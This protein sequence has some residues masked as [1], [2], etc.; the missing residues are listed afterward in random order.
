MP[1]AGISQAGSVIH[2]PKGADMTRSPLLS[3]AATIAV[4]LLVSLLAVSAY[5]QFQTGNIYGKVQAKDGTALPGV[6]VTL[7][8]VAAPQTFLTDSGGN[9]RFLNLSP[10]TYQVRAELSGFGTAVRKDIGVNVG[11]NAEIAITLNPSVEQSITVTAEA[12]LIDTRKTGTGAVVSRAELEQIPTGRDPWV[13]MGQAPGVQLDRVNVAGSE[14]GQQ[15]VVVAKGASDTQKTFNLDGV[16]ITDVGAIGSTPVYY[17]FDSFE[18]IQVTTGGSDPRIQTPGAQLNMVTKRGTNDFKGS[19]RYFLTKNSWQASAAAPSE[20]AAYL[21]QGNTINNVANWSGDVGGPIIKDKLWIWGSIARQDIK[22]FISQPVGADLTH[23]NT[24]LKDWNGKV[25]F[26]PLS[27]N[28]GTYLYTYGNKL[29]FGRYAATDHPQETTEDQ[30]GP[31]HMYKL[32]DTHIFNQNLYLTVLY[33]HVLSPFQFVPEGGNVQPYIDGDGIWHRSYFYYTTSRPQNSYRGDGSYFFKTAALDH[34]LKFGYGYR[35]APVTSLSTYPAT[36]VLGD[37]SQGF[38]G[39]APDNVNGIALLTRPGSNNFLIG[40]TDFYAGDTITTGNLTLQGGLRFDRQKGRNGANPITANPL[41]PDLLAAVT[42][43]A[44]TRELHWNSVSPRIGATYTVGTTH[45]T[46]LRASYN[47]YVDQLGGNVV[48]AGNPYNYAAGLYYYWTDLNHDKTVQRNE[49]GAYYGTYGNIDPDNPNA[50]PHLARLDYGMKPPKTDEFI[51]GAETQLLQDLSVGADYT[52]RKFT[53][54]WW[55]VHEKADGSFVGPNDYDCSSTITAA[56]PNGKS[57]TVPN[58]TLKSGVNIVDTV[59][60]NRPDYNQ[61]Y[62]GFDVFA[63]KRMTNNW[64]MR[65]SFSYNDRKQH[66]GA[67]GI[68]DPTPWLQPPSPITNNYFGCSSCDGAQVVDRSYG[69]HSDTYINAKWQYN[70]TGLYQFPWQISASANLTGRQGYPIPYY[71]RA[72]SK[73]IL[74][75]GVDPEREPNQMELDL[76]LAKDFSLMGR[77]GFQIAAEGFNI[78]NNRPVLQ[79]QPRL[80]TLS[81]GKLSPFGTANHIT[82]VQVPRIFRVSAKISF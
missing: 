59:V 18:E 36:G 38:P 75:D 79:R 35:R 63:T 43:P 65:A 58:C 10:G 29:K 52:Y 71:V 13:I 34:E 16:N 27:N 64:M 23:D 25:N 47:R 78:T 22:L 49:L 66:V 2:Q 31:T 73:R 70:L 81:R 28:S 54:F 17:D 3:R 21:K 68:E 15:D 62:N 32:E 37:F 41:A 30:T 53:D 45:K 50:V 51:L 42:V 57:F 5:A 20:A 76:R 67:R 12:P 60:T 40:Y 72:G 26:Q 55:N 56:L 69:T 48:S 19:A 4:A 46:L 74:L 14:S 6:T 77:G 8:G 7:T 9:F 33:S 39:N 44:D 1:A 24:I 82:E 11:K 61:T 80:Y